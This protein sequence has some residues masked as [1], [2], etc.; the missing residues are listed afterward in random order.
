D[1]GLQK[2]LLEGKATIKASLT[3][4]LHTMQWSSTS[5]YAGQTMDLNGGWESR[6]F[7]LNFSYRFGNNQVK[8]ARQRNTGAD[9]EK[10]RAEGGG[11][12]IGQ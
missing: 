11:G 7:R 4:V 3:D 2:T 10:K 12:G 6:Q 5:N 8:A 9:E 1:I